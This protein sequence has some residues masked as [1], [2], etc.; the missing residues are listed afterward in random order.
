MLNKIIF[1]ANALEHPLIDFLLTSTCHDLTVWQFLQHLPLF[2]QCSE[3][4][5]SL[6]K[7]NLARHFLY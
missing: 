2:Y 1:D 5:F 6:G 3:C 4:K 7:Q